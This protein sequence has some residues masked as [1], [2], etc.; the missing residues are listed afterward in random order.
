MGRG[1]KTHPVDPL[2]EDRG[3]LPDH[4]SCLHSV[5]RAGEPVVADL[6]ILTINALQITAGKKNV[7]DP[8]G[9]TDGR[10]F[11]LMDTN[12]CNVERGSAMTITLSPCEPVDMAIP[13]ALRTIFQFFQWTGKG[14][15]FHY[16]EIFFA[17][18][19][20]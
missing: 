2:I 14:I 18:F 15:K 20:N 10:F 19:G 17:I 9:S 1:D 7:T 4:V 6:V 8:V 11:S 5:H 16:E 3:D 12:G 13:W